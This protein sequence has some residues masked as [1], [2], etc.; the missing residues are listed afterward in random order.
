MVN[1]IDNKKKS[2]MS[3]FV[4]SMKMAVATF[5]SRILGLVREQVMAAMFGASGTTDAFLIAYRIPNMLRDLFAESVFSS[6]FVPIFTEIKQKNP[7]EAKKLLWSVF[8]LLS[9]ITSIISLAIIIFAPE[10]IDLFAPKFVEVPEKFEL[11]VNLIR[12]MSPFLVV[13]ALAALFMGVLN[14]L[15]IFFVPSLAPAFFNIIMIASIIFVPSI[16]DSYG[17]HK[18]ISLGLGVI[19]GGIVQLAIQVP[20]ILSTGYGPKGPIKLISKSTK[21]ILNRVSI[22]TIGVAANQ[23]N[24]LVSTILASTTL[25]GA[26]SWLNYGFRLFQFPVGILGVS[27]AGSNLVHFSE[28]WKQND[29]DRAK[30]YLQASYFLC[31]LTLIPAFALLFSMAT[32]SIHLIFER[33]QFL[34]KDT[35]MTSKALKLYL[36]GLPF[37]GIYKVFSPTFYALDKPK[38]PVI[39]SSLT[40][41]FNIVFCVTLVPFYGFEILALGPSIAIFINCFALTVILKRL[42]N[43]D[44]SFFINLRI[45]KILLSGVICFIGTSW[46]TKYLF[47]F[48]DIFIKKVINFCFVGLAGV[49][50]YVVTL[51]IL[52]ELKSFKGLKR[53]F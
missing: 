50:L 26:V 45:I 31:L 46:L 42:L 28:A 49:F 21:R 11:T 39:C 25:V 17:I 33:G 3:I 13:I 12:I 20:L 10:I 30:K 15:K 34:A 8:C 22:G 44:L 51:A 18:A 24:V 41:F 48:E 7:E 53:K 14:S 29:S 19:L 1:I 6:A 40:I 36:L 37:Y 52:G 27:I 9:I 16:L 5:L 23:I 32:E 47:N 4:S 38:I 2:T 43:L 35:L